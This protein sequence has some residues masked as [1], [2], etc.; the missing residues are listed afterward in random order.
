VLVVG[1]IL[2][3]LGWLATSRLRFSSKPPKPE[4]D[5]TR[6]EQGMLKYPLVV[7]VCLII[8]AV[9]AVAQT[10]FRPG[11]VSPEGLPFA[12]LTA[13]AGLAITW[14]CLLGSDHEEQ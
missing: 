6:L 7:T 10:L 8:T 13:V 12:G 9:L 14:C 2:A 1:T 3:G 11:G 4:S 5:A